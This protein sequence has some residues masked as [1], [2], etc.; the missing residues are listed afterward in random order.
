MLA[1]NALVTR[2]LCSV[3]VSWPWIACS[4][5]GVSFRSLIE[6]KRMPSPL[7]PRL[8]ANVSRELRRVWVSNMDGAAQMKTWGET[9]TP[10]VGQRYLARASLSLLWSRE[11][12]SMPG[13]VGMFGCSAR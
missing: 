9:L 8:R 6:P 7:K 3:P 12:R 10:T 5:R 4:A 11:E 1:A 13:G 2:G